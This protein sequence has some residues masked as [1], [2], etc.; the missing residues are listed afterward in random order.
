MIVHVFLYSRK[1]RLDVSL[2]FTRVCNLIQSTGSD[3]FDGLFLLDNTRISQLSLATGK[4][5]RSLHSL[6][7][8][9]LALTCASQSGTVLAGLTVHGHMFTCLQPSQQLATYI[10]PLSTP[11]PRLEYLNGKPR[12]K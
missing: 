2:C 7:R 8:T 12:N 9:R 11:A 3:I 5:S 6:S 4:T 10:S 1:I